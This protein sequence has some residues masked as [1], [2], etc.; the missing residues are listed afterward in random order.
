MDRWTRF[1]NL[2]WCVWHMN[3]GHETNFLLVA[4][5]LTS[6]PTRP[7]S[8][9]P[10]ILTSLPVARPARFA[11]KVQEKVVGKTRIRNSFIKYGRTPGKI[12]SRTSPGKRAGRDNL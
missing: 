8:V 10:S 2:L 1:V 6:Q 4:S 3:F 7:S 12:I 9:V 5:V 11:Q